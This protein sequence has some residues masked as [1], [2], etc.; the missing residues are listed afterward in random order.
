LPVDETELLV[1]GLLAVV[2]LLLDEAELLAGADEVAT[3]TVGAG[4]G[5]AVPP[6]PAQ[7]LVAARMITAAAP[8]P[9]TPS[10]RRARRDPRPSSRGRESV[11]SVPS[12]GSI[13]RTIPV[14]T[15]ARPSAAGR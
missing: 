10:G 1:G 3:A 11:P 6:I 15:I 5:L 14:P 4:A 7:P 9:I 8:V 12:A 13:T 2:A